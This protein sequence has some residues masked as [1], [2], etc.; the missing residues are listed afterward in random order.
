[1]IGT[2]GLP[3]TVTDGTAAVR[4]PRQTSPCSTCPTSPCCTYLPLHSF[5]V[6]TVAELDHAAYLL[7]FDKIELGL[8]S[9]GTWT[10][11]YR[12]PCRHLDPVDASCRVHAT[13]DQPQICATYN[14]HQCWYKR[15]LTSVTSV[16]HIRLDRARFDLLAGRLTF[17]DGG[18]L[19]AWPEWLDL[20]ELLSQPIAE[21]AIAAP[22]SGAD[23]WQF[24][25]AP[26]RRD[27]AT[28]LTYAEVGDPCDGCAA[29]CCTKLL[30]P[31]PVPASRTNLDHLRF[32][33]GFPGVEV[34]IA[35][36]VWSI[37]VDT[38]CRHLAGGRCSLHGKPERPQLCTYY[39]EWNCSY[40]AQFA[41]ESTAADPRA[42]AGE[43]DLLVSCFRFDSL[44]N[45][46]EMLTADGIGHVL[47]AGVP[48]GELVAAT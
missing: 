28:L 16:D 29:H 45:V 48:A 39:D 24:V 25:A 2:K 46:V 27:A 15:V 22:G 40:R 14:P 1:M 13:A 4:Y 30:F 9:S 33:L 44:G 17:D 43:W 5:S 34:S 8:S 19:T 37:V 21:A 20:V 26:R 10:V 6:S 7:N 38:R 36:P 18:D 31:Y 35:D 32:C 42:G 47:A 11:A 12:Q 23:S 41:P 3:G